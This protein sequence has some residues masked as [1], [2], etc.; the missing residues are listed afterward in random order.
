MNN[1]LKEKYSLV[2]IPALRAELGC[3][4]LFQVPKLLKVVINVG[5]GDAAQNAKF[6]ESGVNELT[7]ISGQKPVISRA[8]KSIAGFKIRQGMPVG[9]MVTLRADRMYDF[10]TK[11]VYYVLPRIRDFRGLTEKGFDGRGNFNIGLKDQLVFP[12]INYDD[13]IRNRGMNITIV[14]SSTN[15]FTARAL[16]NHLGFPFRKSSEQKL[17]A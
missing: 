5:L 16:L 3:S 12:E 7:R 6:L 10:V 13:V 1:H 17:A 14:T 4:N 15:D 9:A 2:I 11:L 8:K